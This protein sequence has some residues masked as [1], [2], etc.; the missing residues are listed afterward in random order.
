GPDPGAVRY[1]L[2]PV[3]ATDDPTAVEG[4]RLEV[5]RKTGGPAADGEEGRRL[6]QDYPL[7]VLRE[8]LHNLRLR[9][10]AE[11]KLEASEE[12]ELR[13]LAR[14]PEPREGAALPEVVVE[15]TPQRWVPG[16]LE[17][18]LPRS[19]LLGEHAH[20]EEDTPV[21]VLRAAHEN[22]LRYCRAAGDRE[23]GAMLVGRVFQQVTPSPELFVVVEAAFE[24]RHADQQSFS[25]TFTTETFLYLERQLARR[26]RRLGRPE[27]VLAGMVHSHPFL[28]AL[29]K[30]GQPLCPACRQ[31]PT[32]KLNSAFY[33]G[34]DE[35]FHRAVFARSAFAVGI[36]LGRDPRGEEVLRVFGVRR[37]LVEERSIWIVD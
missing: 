32:C 31:R 21:F 7:D 4:F 30:D 23:G 33:S 13:V 25:F 11:K 12:L 1:D 36:V 22:A 26:R 6:R 8:P 19:S 16:R 29:D 2:E 27:E 35:L 15:E 37:G 14:R 9:L 17:D 10:L 34:A 28:P 24:A 5:A 18:W 20:V 3:F